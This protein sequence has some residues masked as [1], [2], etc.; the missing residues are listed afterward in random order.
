MEEQ[1]II[2]RAY[3]RQLLQEHPDWVIGQYIEATRRSRK[4]VKK[5]K[6]RL[7]NANPNDDSVLWSESRARHTAPKPYHADVIARI[8]DLR[9]HPPEAVPRKIGPRT[10]LYYLHQDAP[11]KVSG[12]RL[13]RSGSTIWKILDANQ[14]IIRPIK[15]DSNPFDRPD[16]MDTWEID[17][18]DVSTAQ[19]GHDR[20]QQ[21]QVEAFAVM[22]RG[23]SILVDLQAS[24]DYHARTA[25]LA[26]ASTL[27]QHGLPRCIVCDRDPRLI[28]SWSADKFP[29]AFMRFVLDLDIMLDVCSPQRPDQKPFVERYFRTLDEECIQ[30]KSPENL[31][32]TQEVFKDHHYIYNHSRPHQSSVCGNRPPSTA[33]SELPTLAHIPQMVD[34]NGWLQSYDRHLFKRRVNS[35]GRIQIDK[36]M[37][38]IQRQLAGRYVVCQL[39]AQQTVFKVTLGDRVIKTLPIKGLCEGTLEFGDYLEMRLEEAVAEQRRLKHKRRLRNRPVA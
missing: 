28:G 22:D 5:W 23:T 20:K 2:D 4:W 34:P 13:P 24:D 38:Y 6:K 3:L 7:L 32:K 18:T 33:F 17:F 9:D 36:Q 10:I 12:H 1:W 39:D 25:L 29:S 37:Y 15:T 30:Q 14:R 16:P 8:L 19:A 31:T 11:L 26:M 21:H 27:I 35:S